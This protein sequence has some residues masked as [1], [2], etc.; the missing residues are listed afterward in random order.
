MWLLGSDIPQSVPLLSVVLGAGASKREWPGRQSPG[1]LVPL[2]CTLLG[3]PT[4]SGGCSLFLV[5]VGVFSGGDVSRKAPHFCPCQQARVRG[6]VTPQAV[7]GPQD[8]R[9]VSFTLET[10]PKPV[11]LLSWASLV[12]TAFP[13]PMDAG[14]SGWWLGRV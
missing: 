4:L 9:R 14:L 2:G 3:G 11:S 13:V 8:M 10:R 7:S 5:D 6:E 1:K 12:Q